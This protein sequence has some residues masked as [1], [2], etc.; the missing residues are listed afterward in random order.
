M[1]SPQ[2]VHFSNCNILLEW[3]DLGQNSTVLNDN[4]FLNIV[5]F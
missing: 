1:R 2:L 5:P 3:Y 4:Y